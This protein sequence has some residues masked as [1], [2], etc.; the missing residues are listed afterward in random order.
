LVLATPG[1]GL[2]EAVSLA[3]TEANKIMALAARRR[4]TG[5]RPAVR[6]EGRG[7]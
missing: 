5:D 7:A 3:V 2:T 4:A 1:G 6:P